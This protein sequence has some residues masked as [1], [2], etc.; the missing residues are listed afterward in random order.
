MGQILS[1][2]LILIGV[3][4]LWLSRSAPTLQPAS[5]AAIEATERKTA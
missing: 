5:P 2:P 4:L 1:I 3:F